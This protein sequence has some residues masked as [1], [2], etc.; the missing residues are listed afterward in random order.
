MCRDKQSDAA[1]LQPG[2]RKRRA[3]VGGISPV[4]PSD[5][6]QD[7]RGAQFP[8]DVLKKEYSIRWRRD[9][10]FGKGAEQ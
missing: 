3:V 5:K 10:G 1:D 6:T 7:L 4:F 2:H 9:Q 8:T